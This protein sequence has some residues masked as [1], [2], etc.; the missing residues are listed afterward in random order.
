MSDNRIRK[1]QFTQAPSILVKDKKISLASKGLFA[2]MQDKPEGWNFTIKSMTKQLKEGEHTVRKCLKELK[3][4]G[5]ITYEKHHDGTGTYSINFI[6]IIAGPSVDNPHVENQHQA[7]GNNPNAENPHV[8]NPHVDIPMM[9]NSTR[10]KQTDSLNKQIDKQTDCIS[11]DGSPD[12]QPSKRKNR[13]FDFSGLSISKLLAEELI[14][15]RKRI[16]KDPLTQRALTS[17]SKKIDL[18]AKKFQVSHE[19]VIGLMQEKGWK[20]IDPSWE[21]PLISN[22]ELQGRTVDNS[23]RYYDD[24]LK[25]AGMN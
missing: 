22:P 8:E 16:K 12:S 13:E 25:A 23:G 7:N 17:L 15:Y 3:D 2:F 21:L 19:D 18:T 1:T 5:W 11:G 14:D 9:R 4:N 6:P 24:I 20:A 10:I